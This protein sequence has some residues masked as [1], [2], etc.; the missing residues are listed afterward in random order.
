MRYLLVATALFV[1]STTGLEAKSN[2]GGVDPKGVYDFAIINQGRTMTGRMVV[3]DSAGKQIGSIAPDGM[4]EPLAFDS[5]VTTAKDFTAHFTIPGQGQT[6]VTLAA[7][8]GDS[9][10]GKVSGSVGEMDMTAV[11]LRR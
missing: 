6:A 1:A 4:G 10:K 3:R 11:R 5:V 7:T 2:G 8:Q 9:L